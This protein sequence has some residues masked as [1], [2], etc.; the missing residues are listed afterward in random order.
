MKHYKAKQ[1]IPALSACERALQI[2]P[3]YTRALHGK[4][5]AAIKLER[6]QEAYESY[7]QLYK[8]KPYTKEILFWYKEILIEYGDMLFKQKRYADA[9]FRYDEALALDDTNGIII[10]K[11][12]KALYAFEGYLREYLPEIWLPGDY[13]KNIQL[14]YVVSQLEDLI[15]YSKRVGKEIPDAALD[16]IREELWKIPDVLD[17]GW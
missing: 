1:Y 9:L 15:S 11:K 8:S 7:Y 6:Y 5:L 17:D 10:D 4:A 16:R 14:Q 3:Y 13:A 2:D 12:I